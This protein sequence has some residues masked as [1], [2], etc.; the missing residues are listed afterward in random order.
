MVNFEHTSHLFLAYLLLNFYRLMFNSII[1]SDLLENL[2]L[3][4]RHL[5]RYPNLLRKGNCLNL[6]QLYYFLLASWS[7]YLHTVDIDLRGI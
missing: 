7:L 6:W 5:A 2:A 1:I 3:G 4:H